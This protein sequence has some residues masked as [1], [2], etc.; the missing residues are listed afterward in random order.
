MKKF[1]L[2]YFLFIVIMQLQFI[3][4]ANAQSKPAADEQKNWMV[5]LAKIE[6]DTAWLKEYKA[7]VEEHTKA[8]LKLEPGVLT[9]YVMNEKAHPEKVTVLEIYASKEAYQVHIKTAHFL[10]YKTSTA[11]MVKSLELIDVEPIE[12]LSKPNLLGY[13]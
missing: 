8:A 13:K 5:R 7:A 2:K 12:F 9:L 11:H 3:A 6:V 4:P 1:K 10:K